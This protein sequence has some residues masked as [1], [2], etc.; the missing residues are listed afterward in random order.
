VPN[1]VGA[2]YFKNNLSRSFPVFDM[3]HSIDER[4]HNGEYSIK[5]KI[6]RYKAQLLA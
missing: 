1:L 5:L 6:K 2:K 4:I 3:S